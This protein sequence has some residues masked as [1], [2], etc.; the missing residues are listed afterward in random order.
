M[1]AGIL[2]S[3]VARTPRS[4]QSERI[5]EVMPPSLAGPA[6]ETVARALSGLP[7]VPWEY[8]LEN[9]DGVRRY[10]AQVEAIGSDQAVVLVR[11]VT[12]RARAERGQRRSQRRLWAGSGHSFAAFRAF[13]S[14]RTKHTVYASLL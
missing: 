13:Q 14:A 2:A 6:M 3:G 4:K 10:R 11:D 12:D 1:A 9:P 8:D 7:S 5:G